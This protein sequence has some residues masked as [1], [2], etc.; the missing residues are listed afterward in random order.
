MIYP[1]QFYMIF[2]LHN[3]PIYYLN[4]LFHLFIPG[5]PAHFKLS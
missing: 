1:T 5:K 3:Q 2:S 4:A